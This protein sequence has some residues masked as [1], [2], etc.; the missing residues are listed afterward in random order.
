MDYTK[1]PASYTPST[2]ATPSFGQSG[3]GVLAL[4]KSYNTQHAGQSGFIPLKED[5]LYGPKTY[6]ALNPTSQLVVTS[7]PSRT[8]TNEALGGLSEA[9]AR[10]NSAQTPQQPTDTT[11]GTDADPIMQGLSKLQSTSDAASKSLL[12]TISAQYA[13]EKNKVNETYDAYKGGLQQLGIETNA[14]EATPDLLMGHIQKAGTEQLDKIHALNA[15]ESKALM[16]ASAAKESNDFRTL[17]TKMAYVKEI[18]QKKADAIKEMYDRIATSTK[19]AAI[20]AHDIYDTM[21]TLDAA[22]KEAFIQA[23]AK[24]YNLPVLSLVQALKDEKTKRDSDA[25]DV[26][27]KKS[28]IAN[29]NKT[30]GGA[31][32]LKGGTDGTYKYTG[33][34]LNAYKSLIENGGTGPDG[35]PY[36]GRGGDTYVDPYAYKAVYEDWKSNGGTPAGFLKKFPLSNVNPD[37]YHLLAPELQ[38]KKKAGSSHGPLFPASK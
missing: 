4:Q 34:D 22:D 1:P 24:K 38:P 18:K 17:Q 6:A 29:R 35:R 28:I 3:A 26:A 37:S 16:D 19:T 36:N 21:Q 33:D 15:E 2:S 8:K 13:N 7:A 5:S 20:E 10:L 12:A 9:L 30:S 23:V 31:T 25:L 11:E 27:D 32:T 14:A